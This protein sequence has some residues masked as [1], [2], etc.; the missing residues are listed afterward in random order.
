MVHY[1]HTGLWPIMFK[2]RICCLIGPILQLNLTVRWH[3][4]LGPAGALI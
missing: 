1:V 4:A 2:F 3:I